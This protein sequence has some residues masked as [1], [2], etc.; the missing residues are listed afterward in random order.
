MNTLKQEFDSVVDAYIA[1]FCRK[2][3]FDIENSFWVTDRKGE[4]FEVADYYFGFDDIRFDIDNNLQSKM[5]LDW[6]E[7]TLEHAVYPEH[8]NINLDSWVMGL[9]YEKPFT[10]F[11]LLKYRLQPILN[12]IHWYFVGKR[13]IKAKMKDHFKQYL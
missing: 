13:Q 4:I 10:R 6:Y 7:A 11:Q 2:H 12:S 8:H 3:E 5:I 1:A 9:R